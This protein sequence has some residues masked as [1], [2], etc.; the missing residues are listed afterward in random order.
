VSTSELFINFF[1]NLVAGIVGILIVLWIER[2]RRPHLTIK[3]GQPGRLDEGDLLNR[4]PSTWLHVQ[5]QNK[6]VPKWLMWV[7]Q[8]EPALTCKAWITFHHLDGKKIFDRDMIARWSGS[9]EPKVEVITTKE[10][11]IARLVGA[12]D[13]FDIPPGENTDVDV[14]FRAK[15]EDK[16]YGWNNESYLHNWRHP[17]WKLEKG[18]YIARIRIKT[19]GQEYF[20]S[21]IVANDGPYSDFR[22]IEIDNEMKKKIN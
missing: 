18:S 9:N 15:A 16:C 17:D 6:N 14:V 4:S 13:T 21:F 5:V 11:K 10:G 7:Y 19:G 20:N 8:G 12:Q 22:L 3:L 2:Q 1:I